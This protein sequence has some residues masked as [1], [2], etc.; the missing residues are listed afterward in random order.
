MGGADDGG[1]PKP[2]QAAPSVG[3]APQS[4]VD[5]AVS[6]TSSSHG[7]L[8]LTITN[9]E[10]GESGVML[11]PPQMRYAVGRASYKVTYPERAHSCACFV[12][13]MPYISSL[14]PHRQ[15]RRGGQPCLG[16][17]WC[18]RRGQRQLDRPPQGSQEPDRARGASS[19][20][21][22]ACIRSWVHLG[23]LRKG[24]SVRA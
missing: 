5:P 7:A 1:G 18:T 21:L 8:L 16:I 14:S 3:E 12:L 22:H 23:G 6:R 4:E 15:D 24:G 11:P 13:S 2:P 19:S 20:H 9:G 17:R 10:S